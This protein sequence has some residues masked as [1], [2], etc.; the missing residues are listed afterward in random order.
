[1]YWDFF[2]LVDSE[3]SGIIA[4]D[5]ISKIT[6]IHRI[7]ASRWFHQ[8]SELILREIE[9]IGLRGELKQYKAD[10]QVR[11]LGHVSPI[12]WNATEGILEVL[13]PQPQKIADFKE[14]PTALI[15]HSNSTPA[16]GITASLVYVGKGNKEEHYK[17]KE[18]KGKIVLAHGR[19]REVHR[20]AVEKFGAEGIV[21]FSKNLD[22]P[23]GYPYMSF[24]P[25]KS[26]VEKI[27]F[28]F[29][30]PLRTANKLISLLEDGKEVK[31]RAKVKTEFF[32][33]N[34][35]VITTKIE[36]TELKD[37]E[38]LLIA[39]ICHP[40]P[41]ANDNASGSGLLLE[42]L[43]TIKKLIDEKKI[44]LKRT[45]RF[46][47]VPEFFGT[48]AY[49]SENKRSIN[50]IKFGINLDMVGEDQ[51][52]TK[53]VL[54]IVDTPLSRYSFIA[55]VL[56]FLIKSAA[57][58]D[59]QQ[60][61][62]T[63]GLPQIRFKRSKY[64][65]GSDHSVFVDANLGIPFTAIIQWPDRFYHSSTDDISKVSPVSLKIVGNAVATLAITLANPSSIDALIFANRLFD[66]VSENLQELERRAFASIELINK[67]KAK[68]TLKSILYA[69]PQVAEFYK[70]AFNDVLTYYSEDKAITETIENYKNDVDVL[71]RKIIDRIKLAMKAKKIE[72]EKIFIDNDYEKRAKQIIPIRKTETVF[73]FN[74]LQ[75]QLPAERYNWY[76]H[77]AE[78]LI[79]IKATS[80]ELFNFMNGKRS[81]YDIY[82]LLVAEF[83]YLPLDLL[84]E[85]LQDFK[86]YNYVSF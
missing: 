47:W 7:Q 42:I 43:R 41:G 45:L 54:T 32:E 14:V 46:L 48:F 57:E 53:S 44:E 72:E 36:G 33:G 16:E 12:G 18:V 65:D 80:D 24:W 51:D 73:F 3:L 59:L 84:I 71:T 64:S 20:L 23:D 29:T 21:L 28:G 67:D 13:E 22:N 38:I 77:N 10:G 50:K 37:E 6:Q 31:V 56:E 68:T 82:T 66:A 34:L 58:K 30:I 74:D 15:T 69:L 40:K 86:E 75:K 27:K 4:K 9:K 83:R 5:Y 62:S 17:S 61:G 11:Y 1:M 76:I 81:L 26:E 70:I 55:P 8:A 2:R 49:V 79:A 35:D 39:H 60:I 52:L 85:V 78:K 19:P 63:E 25:E